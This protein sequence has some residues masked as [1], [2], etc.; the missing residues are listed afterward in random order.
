[1]DSY[2]KRIAFKDIDKAFDMLFPIVAA[3]HAHGVSLDCTFTCKA[4]SDFYALCGKRYKLTV[5]GLATLAGSVSGHICWAIRHVTEY[6][7]PDAVQAAMVQADLEK[8]V[9]SYLRS[10]EEHHDEN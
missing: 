6:D 4:L 10:G 2:K 3:A 7:H 8:M 9:E 5:K 1:M